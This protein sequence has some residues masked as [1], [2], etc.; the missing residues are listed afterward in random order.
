MVAFNEDK[1]DGYDYEQNAKNIM[2]EI[3]SWIQ[4]FEKGKINNDIKDININVFF[5]PM[6]CVDTFRETFKKKLGA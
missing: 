1:Y 5:I 6:T 2:P 4:N 3:E